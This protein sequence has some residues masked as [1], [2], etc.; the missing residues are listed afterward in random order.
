MSRAGIASDVG[1]LLQLRSSEPRVFVFQK[2]LAVLH[3]LWDRSFLTRD[4]THTL[5]SES[6]GVL[7]AGLQGNFPSLMF[8][9]GESH[10]LRS[11]VG[12]SPCC[13]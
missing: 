7:N 11:L 12:C 3:G 9:P 4:G 2:F 5:G 8:L 6:H 10:G 13:R 1:F